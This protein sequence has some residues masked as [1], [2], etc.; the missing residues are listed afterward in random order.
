MYLPALED[1]VLG[2]RAKFPEKPRYDKPQEIAARRADLLRPRPRLARS[3]STLIT[4]RELQTHY[5]REII[6]DIRDKTKRQ[7]K[8]L[9]TS[10][11]LITAQEKLIAAQDRDLQ[12][13][14]F[15]FSELGISV[16]LSLFL[17][18]FDIWP[19]LKKD[20]RVV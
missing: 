10:D 20:L 3:T 7:H 19:R 8:A 14:L 18:Y 12:T 5:L 9:G 11:A 6:T 16:M 15:I 13:G 2:G 4:N 17:I 1:A